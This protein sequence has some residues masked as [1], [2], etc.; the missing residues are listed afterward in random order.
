MAHD[1]A[2]EL[3]YIL[4]LQLNQTIEP[5]QNV[6]MGENQA[7][8]SLKHIEIIMCVEESFGV[9]FLTQEI[10]EL[11]S[12]ARLLARLQELLGQA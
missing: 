11:T 8:D 7:W 2:I 5:D 4:S 9:S 12:Q 3:A 1:V 10:P 6:S